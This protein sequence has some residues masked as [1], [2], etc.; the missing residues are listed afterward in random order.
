MMIGAAEHMSLDK[1]RKFVFLRN[2]WLSFR[3]SNNDVFLTE[4]VF[5]ANAGNLP[6]EKCLDY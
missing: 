5:P 4:K 1:T 3:P 6:S 2:K